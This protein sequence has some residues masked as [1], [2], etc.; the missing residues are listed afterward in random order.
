MNGRAV[1]GKKHQLHNNAHCIDVYTWRHG[2]HVAGVN[3]ETV[4][5]LEE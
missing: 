2:G 4:A 3:K 1:V 5:I